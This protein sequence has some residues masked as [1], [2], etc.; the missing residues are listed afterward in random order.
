VEPDADDAG[1]GAARRPR[2]GGLR[3]TVRRL[4]LVLQALLCTALVIWSAATG[5]VAYTAIAATLL[6]VAVV[7]LV[8]EFRDRPPRRRPDLAAGTDVGE[9]TADDDADHTERRQ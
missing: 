6:A 5:E 7:V 2:R 1:V 9:G 8:R 3:R 4:G